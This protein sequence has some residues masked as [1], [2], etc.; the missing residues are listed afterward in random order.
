MFT[1]GSLAYRWSRR[2]LFLCISQLHKP[3]KILNKGSRLFDGQRAHH[4]RQDGLAK[5][6]REGSFKLVLKTIE[7]SKMQF[8]AQQ[9]RYK[10]R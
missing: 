10:L 8:L 5:L 3:Y 9:Q 4:L 7:A 2:D 1:F 6:E